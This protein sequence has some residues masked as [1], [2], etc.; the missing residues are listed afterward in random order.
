MQRETG[1]QPAS[2][3][4]THLPLS[5]P[6]HA[7]IH[8]QERALPG[9]SKFPQV[10]EFWT[11]RIS[12]TSDPGSCYP[13]NTML[14]FV[15][16]LNKLLRAGCSRREHAFIPLSR[17]CFPRRRFRVQRLKYVLSIRTQTKNIIKSKDPERPCAH[18]VYTLWP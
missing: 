5:L 10:Y 13:C 11:L 15:E 7:H 8:M 9:C 6:A 12:E 18:T 17:R 16:A 3:P 1:R 14:V 4:P 2:Q